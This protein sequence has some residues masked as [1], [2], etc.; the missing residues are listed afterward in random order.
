MHEHSHGKQVKNSRY[1]SR[2]TTLG[3]GIKSV[4]NNGSL[5]VEHGSKKTEDFKLWLV[6]YIQV[7]RREQFSVFYLSVSVSHCY[8]YLINNYFNTFS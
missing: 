7:C 3:G 1:A 2:H 6:K 5:V 4:K 8:T